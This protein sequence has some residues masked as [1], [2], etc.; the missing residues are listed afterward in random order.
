MKDE[1][2]AR[3]KSITSKIVVIEKVASAYRNKK[4]SK[5]FRRS[6]LTVNPLTRTKPG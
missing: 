6:N 2:D 5:D 4:A 1:A 3:A